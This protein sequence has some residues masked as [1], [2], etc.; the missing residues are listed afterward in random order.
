MKG[1]I[2][3]IVTVMLLLTTLT[4]INFIYVGV[5]F[6]SLAAETISTNHRNIEYTA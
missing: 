1:K 3:K 5:G 6:I 2:I 4:M